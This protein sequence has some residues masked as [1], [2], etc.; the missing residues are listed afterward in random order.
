MIWLITL[1][2]LFGIGILLLRIKKEHGHSMEDVTDAP[3]SDCQTESCGI[4]CFCDDETLKRAVKT[5][6]EYF[7][8][9]HLDQYRGISPE[10]Y[11]EAQIA[12]F[13]EVLT[14]LRSE[15]VADWL[16]SLELRHIHLPSSL[17]D[18]AVIL[19]QQP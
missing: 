11:D 9:E 16:R 12:A 10:A 18:E 8:D 14:T 3:S 5:Q 4:S 1:I 19:M 2:L 15:E 7:E 6:I 17:K 13:S